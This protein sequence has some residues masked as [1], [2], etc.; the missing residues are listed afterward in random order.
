MTCSCPCLTGKTKLHLNLPSQCIFGAVITFHLIFASFHTGTYHCI[1]RYKKSYSVATKD[2]MVHPLP[3]E[4]DIMV[5]PLE[6]TVPCKGSRHFRCCIE[7]DEDYKVTF[8]VDSLFFLAG[9]TRIA[10]LWDLKSSSE[11]RGKET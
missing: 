4:P 8:Q 2:V 6:A 11:N 5:D 10:A 3:L 9:K 7:E 1:F